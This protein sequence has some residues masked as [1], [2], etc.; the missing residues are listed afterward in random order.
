MTMTNNGAFVWRN[1]AKPAVGDE[2]WAGL[3]YQLVTTLGDVTVTTT[4]TWD[5]CYN[6]MQSFIASTGPGSDDAREMAHRLCYPGSG[7]GYRFWIAGEL[8]QY[9]LSKVQP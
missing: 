6:A 3:T 7:H 1:P 9:E 4:G 5:E 2:W 8:V